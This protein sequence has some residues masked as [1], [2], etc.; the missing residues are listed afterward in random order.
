MAIIFLTTQ[1]L[2]VGSNFKSS[3]ISKKSTEE[4]SK[5]PSVLITIFTNLTCFY[6]D[7][8]LISRHLYRFFYTNK[9]SF[10]VGKSNS[11]KRIKADFR[12]CT[13]KSL[14]T[15]ILNLQ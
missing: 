7:L 4:L 13:G 6:L 8:K 2:Q 3:S 1:C 10:K 15:K 12:K 5:T 9:N 14:I 11:A